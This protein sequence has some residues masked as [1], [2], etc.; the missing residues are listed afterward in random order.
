MKRGLR[1]GCA[2]SP[3]LFNI[4]INRVL[5]EMNEE[6]EGIRIEGEKIVIAAFADD[7]AIY[8]ANKYRMKMALESLV[9]K[10]ENRG[11]RLHA[12][13]SIILKK[14]DA[15]TQQKETLTVHSAN[16]ATYEFKE[17]TDSIRYLGMWIAIGD[18][19]MRTSEIVE[20]KVAHAIWRIKRMGRLQ[21]DQKVL[22]ANIFRAAMGLMSAH[23]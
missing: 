9:T 5:H 23:P 12:D 3:I 14:K 15:A 18:S 2:M 17:S 6:H 8:A 7:M 10:L 19:K 20:T 16:G 1:Q 22:I 4:Y 21:I 11:L 13:K